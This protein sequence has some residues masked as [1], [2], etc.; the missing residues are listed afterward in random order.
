M[1]ILRTYLGRWSSVSS[2]TCG[3]T[4][5]LPVH[6]SAMQPADLP[7]RESPALSLS[8]SFSQAVAELL[9]TLDLEKKTVAV[10]H[11]QVSRASSFCRSTHDIRDTRET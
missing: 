7:L 5:S 11:S 10:G 8:S 3:V 1:L 2:R 6:P 4:L 9:Q